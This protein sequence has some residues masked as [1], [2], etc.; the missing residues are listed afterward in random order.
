MYFI[1][2]FFLR[3]IPRLRGLVI[4]LWIILNG[5]KCGNLI[6]E[7]GFRLKYPPHKG[8]KLGNNI[9][10]GKHVN[11]DVPIGSIITIGDDVSFTGYTYISVAEALFIGSHVIIGEFVSIRDANHGTSLE[12]NVFIKDQKMKPKKIE[13]EDNIWIG[14]GVCILSGVRITSGSVIGSNAVVNKPLLIS[15]AIYAGIPC[16][17]IKNRM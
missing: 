15:N 7:S 16:K 8:F 12:A 3:I 4:R 10:F 17:Y 2:L 1:Q 13:I 9:C 5:G 6:V 11:L 14:R